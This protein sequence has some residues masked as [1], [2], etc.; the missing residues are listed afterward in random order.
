MIRVAIISHEWYKD[1][2]YLQEQLER[3]ASLHDEVIIIH[4]GE[5]LRYAMFLNQWCR[6][7]DG[8]TEVT[9][10]KSARVY[11]AGPGGM[12]QA[13]RLLAHHPDEVWKFET[14]PGSRRRPDYAIFPEFWALACAAGAKCRR[15]YYQKRKTPY[16]TYMEAPQLDSNGFPVPVRVRR[17]DAERNDVRTRS[18]RLKGYAKDPKGKWQREERRKGNLRSG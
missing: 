17:W 16:K 9:E 6:T 14:S 7:H 10:P 1:Y 5:P 13:E 15:F 8:F 2:P 12:E 18:G 3:L 11:G 4:G